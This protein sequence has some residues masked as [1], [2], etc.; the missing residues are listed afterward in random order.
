MKTAQQGRALAESLVTTGEQ[1][2]LKTSAL[3]TDMNQPLGQMIGNALE[4]QEAIDL[5]QGEGPEDLAQL[6]FALASEL[7]LSSNTA[8]NDEE[9]R[10]LLSE[11][12]SSGRGYEKFIE[13]ILAQ[14]GD[15][16]A[17]RPLGSLHESAVTTLYVQHER[18][19]ILGQLLAHDT[20]CN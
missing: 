10:H 16:N 1:M 11:H 3:L 8:N 17:Q 18:V 15:P 2:G 9:A 19:E 7:L 4:V 20:G 14:G 5:L 12:L 13:M 6:T